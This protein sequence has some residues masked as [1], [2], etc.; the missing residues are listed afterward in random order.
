MADILRSRDGAN[1]AAGALLYEA[2][3][4]CINAL[5]NSH[6]A[7]PGTTGGKYRFLRNLSEQ[8]STYLVLMDNWRSAND[9]HLN[10]DRLTMSDQEFA[11]AWEQT[12]LF[13][14]QM[15]QIYSLGE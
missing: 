13:I 7:N 15:L 6:G 12:Q 10:A 11:I 3:K 4:Q 2:A 1:A 9:L 5:A 8:E 14:D